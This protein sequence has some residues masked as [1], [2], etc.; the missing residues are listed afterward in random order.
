MNQQEFNQLLD[1]VKNHY[2][3][4]CHEIPD[5][6]LA[7]H[8]HHVKVA[9]YDPTKKLESEGIPLFHTRDSL[10]AYC[11]SLGGPD[12]VPLVLSHPEYAT[13]KENRDIHEAV[14]EACTTKAIKRN[15]QRDRL[16]NVLRCYVTNFPLFS[17]IPHFSGSRGMFT[18]RP[19]FVVSAGPSLDKNIHLLEKAKEYG[20]VM[21]VNTAMKPVVASMGDVDFMVTVES[22]GSMRHIGGLEGRAKATLCDVGAARS[23]L[24]WART[25]DLPFLFSPNHALVQNIA[26][27]LGVPS[28]SYGAS[29]ATA[30]VSLAVGNGASHVILVGQ[31]CAY[32]EDGRVYAKGTV[33]EHFRWSVREED[34]W[35]YSGDGK[36]EINQKYQPRV[37]TKGWDGSPFW[38]V[39]DLMLFSR[40]FSFDAIGKKNA[41]Y[42][43]KFWNCTEGGMYLEG[44]DHIKLENALSRLHRLRK[45]KWEPVV[46]SMVTTPDHYI[47]D[48]LRECET[49]F[50][51]AFLQTPEKC[52]QRLMSTPLAREWLFVTREPTLENAG[53]S[54]TQLDSQGNLRFFNDGHA[55]IDVA[56]RL[57]HFRAEFGELL[58]AAHET[59]DQTAKGSGM[60]VWQPTVPVTFGATGVSR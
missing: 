24:D 39:P 16:R 51:Q 58:E 59:H 13:G 11:A 31:D 8:Q 32:A 53:Q 41:N 44:Y 19:V 17:G 2:L 27:R 46:N 45:D 34:G 14:I 21:V 30:A 50:N 7:L 5:I 52:L 38:T 49:G 26:Y 1:T 33:Y 25:T 42:P 18:G 40:W 35:I 22:L 23:S 36:D 47:E 10:M 57:D 37:E 54:M 12:D 48:L 60:E 56:D 3:V 43:C 28:V 55:W 9:I 29:V 4:I 15:T 20:Y 6:A